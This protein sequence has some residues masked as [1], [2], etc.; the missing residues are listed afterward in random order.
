MADAQEAK[1]RREV[2]ITSGD[3]NENFMMGEYAD[4]RRYRSVLVLLLLLLF[5]VMVQPSLGLDHPGRLKG[6]VTAFDAA[7]V[8]D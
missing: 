3:R 7:F 1:E 8:R 4:I 2:R 6:F 5:K